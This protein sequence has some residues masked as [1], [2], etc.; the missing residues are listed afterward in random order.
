[1]AG[2]IDA[3]RDKIGP[4]FHAKPGP[5]C[6]NRLAADAPFGGLHSVDVDAHRLADAAA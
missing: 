3:P 2:R 6:S 5:R 4:G 1:M